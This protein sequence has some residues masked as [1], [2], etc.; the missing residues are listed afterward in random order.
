MRAAGY[1]IGSSCIHRS[2]F[3]SGIDDI[4]YSIFLV[5]QD[6]GEAVDKDSSNGV[7]HDGQGLR[8]FLQK[9]TNILVVDLIE[10]DEDLRLD[11]RL[12][13]NFIKHIIN[14][15]GDETVFFLQASIGPWA[16]TSKHG[17][18]LAGASHAVDEDGGVETL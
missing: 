12:F 6:L 7:L 15:H 17:V 2:L 5:G 11:M 10:G 8:V 13:L 1:F 16:E 9:V 3:D 14:S 18:S 4:F